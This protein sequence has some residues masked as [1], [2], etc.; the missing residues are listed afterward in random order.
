MIFCRE[1]YEKKN[2]KRC[3]TKYIVLFRDKLSILQLDMKFR[4]NFGPHSK[5]EQS[6]PLNSLNLHCSSGCVKY[7]LYGGTIT[8]VQ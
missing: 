6:Q 7:R 3:M 8:L 5:P 1:R 2:M 4:S